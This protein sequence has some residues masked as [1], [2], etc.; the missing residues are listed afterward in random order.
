MDAIPTE[1]PSHI[2]GH[3]FVSFSSRCQTVAGA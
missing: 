1:L 2:A 3:I